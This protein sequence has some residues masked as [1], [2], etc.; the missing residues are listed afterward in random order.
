MAVNK[1]KNLYWL[2]IHVLAYS[3]VT[4]ILWIQFSPLI[5]DIPY[6]FLITFITHWLTDLIT[7]RLAAYFKRKNNESLYYKTLGIDQL[8]HSITLLLTYNYLIKTI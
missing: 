1:S 7:S 3:T 4:T 2:T 8:I 6:I 5:I